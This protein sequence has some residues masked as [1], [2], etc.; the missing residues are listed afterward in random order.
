[1]GKLLNQYG[2]FGLPDRQAVAMVERG[3]QASDSEVTC[4][5]GPFMRLSKT[6]L[7]LAIAGLALA[8][9]TGQT[10]SAQETVDSARRGQSDP[11]AELMRAHVKAIDDIPLSTKPSE[12]PLPVDHSGK[13]FSGKTD[14][15]AE[16][17]WPMLEVNWE[18]SELVFQPPYWEDT[19][20]ERYGQ[21]RFP[22]MQPVVSGAHFFGTF[23]IV[24]YKIGIDRTHD[25]ISA[26]GYYRPGSPAPCLRQRL[27]WEWDAALFEAAAWSGMSFILP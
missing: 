22:R 15:Y 4:A 23:A 9:T 26:L 27:P 6:I 7:A 10:A 13:L 16:R 17:A 3:T 21:T 8:M 5:K 12:G 24:P 20:L 18:A 11:V 14:A 1:M 19:P 2:L 25:R